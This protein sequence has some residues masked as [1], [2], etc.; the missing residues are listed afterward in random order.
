MEDLRATAVELYGSGLSDNAYIAALAADLR[1]SDSGVRKWWYRQRHV[2]GPA[3]VALDL[4]RESKE[5]AP[6][7]SPGG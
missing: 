4:L 5:R 7:T 6:K 2:P 1:A 3:L